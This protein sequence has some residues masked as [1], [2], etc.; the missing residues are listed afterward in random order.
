MIPEQVRD[1][2]PEQVRDDRPEHVRDGMG[3]PL[4][5]TAELPP[6]LHAF[7]DRLR[8]AHFPKERNFLKAHVTLF[9]ALPASC[10]AE[11]RECL[12]RLAQTTRPVSARLSSVMSLG[13]GTALQIESRAMLALRDE[14]ADRFHGMLTAQDQH[15]PRLHVTVQNKVTPGAAKLLLAELSATFQPRDFNFRGLALHAYLGGPW[16]RLGTYAFRG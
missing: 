13:R 14:I 4:I 6:D 15:R 8:Q 10:E 16:D 1:D 5:V 11:A 12:A 9:H 3:Y 7:A 2:R